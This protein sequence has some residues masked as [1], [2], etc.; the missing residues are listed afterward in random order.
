MSRDEDGGVDPKGVGRTA[1]DI[2]AAECVFIKVREAVG[3]TSI[4][5][6]FEGGDGKGDGAG[7]GGV[8]DDRRDVN[9]I[10]RTDARG[11]GGDGVGDVKERVV[12][13]LDDGVG[14]GRRHG[15]TCRGKGHACKDKGKEYEKSIHIIYNV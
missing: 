7:S 9:A 15:G 6:A 11:V 5:F 1:H 2:G 14:E 10:V 13:P 3:I 12:G 4:T 8:G